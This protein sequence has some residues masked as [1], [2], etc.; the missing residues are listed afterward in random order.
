MSTR[1]AESRR[2]FLKTG[3]AVTAGL[4][5]ATCLPGCSRPAPPRSDAPFA[6]N[7]WVRVLGDGSVT[8]VIDRSE[9][10]QG[11]LTALAMLAAEELDADWARLRVEQAPANEAYVNPAFPVPVQVTGASASVRAAWLPMRQAGAKARAMLVAA[12]AGKWGVEPA[13][14]S[15]DKGRVIH[16]A[17]GRT[18]G[19]G[20]LAEHAAKLPVPERTV[21]KDPK[22]FRLIGQPLKRVDTRAKVTAEAQF[23]IDVRVPGMRVAVVA[24]C[25]VLGGKLGKLDERKARAVP[26]VQQVF[27]IDSGVAVVADNYWAATKGREALELTWDEG[28]NAKLSTEA[29]R[30]A[31]KALAARG[32]ARPAR[33]EGDAVKALGAAAGTITASYELP[34]LAH[35]AMEPMN[36]TAHVEKDRCRVWAPTQYQSGFPMFLGGGALNAA[37][38][39]SGLSADRIEIHTT[40]LGGGFGRRLQSDFVFE[41]VQVSKKAGAPVKVVWS[42]EDDTANDFYRPMSYHELRATLGSDGMPLALHHRIVAPSIILRDLPSWMPG[43]AADWFGATHDGVDESAVEGAFDMPYAIPNLL[44]DWVLAE[45]P[46]PIGY[47]RSVGHSYNAFVVESFIDELAAAAKLDPFEF[48][49]KLLVD[50]PR[51]LKVLELAAQKAGWGRALPKGRFHGIAL[52]RPFLSY[53]A[54]VAEVSIENGAPRVHRVVCAVDCGQVVNPNI[55]EQQISGGVVFGLAALL[56]GEITFQNGRVQ[57]SNFHDYPVTRMRESPSIEVHVVQSAEDPTGTGEPGVPSLAPA[58]CNAIFRATGKR[59]RSLPVRM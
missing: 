26:G 57:Q 16:E 17:S 46:V 49:R 36:C 11:V 32:E 54:E 56:H 45:T 8:I 55:V 6:P 25:P 22:D 28:P 43:F 15:T 12:A 59:L 33:K 38:K 29:L 47:W 3:V 2:E 19:Y 44:V 42:R 1:S 53:V 35:A 58:V 9:M 21:L 40:Q 13:S 10:G 39:A 48:R 24:R 5:V 34:F 37:K 23:G 14:C 4:T 41:A 50:S 51:H 27:A 30:A 18:L 52:S 7:A 20:E 31:F